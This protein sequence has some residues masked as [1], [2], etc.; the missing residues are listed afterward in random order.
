MKSLMLSGVLML[1][2]SFSCLGMDLSGISDNNGV[3]T[4]NIDPA[5]TGDEYVAASVATN[6]TA[7]TIVRVFSIETLGENPGPHADV[8]LTASRDPDFAIRIAAAKALVGCDPDA[9]VRTAKGI[10]QQL[11][12]AQP[13]FQGDYL[14]GLEAAA[15]LA[16]LND[17]SGFEFVANRLEHADFSAEK[18]MALAYLPDFQVVNKASATEAILTFIETTVSLLEQSNAAEKHEAEILLPKAFNALYRLQAIEA[19]PR[20]KAII[21]LLNEHLQNNIQYYIQ[22][23]EALS[24]EPLDLNEPRKEG[25]ID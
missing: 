18:V 4:I 1:A 11:S 12:T 5:I 23:L 25:V 22:K 15:L 13:A 3:L 17:P 7:S 8:L 21:P 14:Y 6:T 9:A 24:I 10:V 16:K 2:I 19:I 20:L